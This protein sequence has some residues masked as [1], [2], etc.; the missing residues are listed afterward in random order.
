[1]AIVLQHLGCTRSD[2]K[3]TQGRFGGRPVGGSVLDS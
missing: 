1:M 3:V 2:V